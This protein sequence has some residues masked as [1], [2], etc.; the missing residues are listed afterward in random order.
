MTYGRKGGRKGGN[1]RIIFVK[2]VEYF[3]SLCECALEK[4]HFISVS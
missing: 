1:E 4:A 2:L 3:Y